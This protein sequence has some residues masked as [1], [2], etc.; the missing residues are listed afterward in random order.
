MDQIV[1]NTAGSW[2]H[3]AALEHLKAL[4]DVSVEYLDGFVLPWN[5]NQDQILAQEGMGTFPIFLRI[6]GLTLNVQIYLDSRI[7]TSEDDGGIIEHFMVQLSTEYFRKCAV[8]DTRSAY[9]I[10]EDKDR[11][12]SF[13]F[14]V[15]GHSD[16]ELVFL[17]LYHPENSLWFERIDSWHVNKS[18]VETDLKSKI[19]VPESLRG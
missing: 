15:M 1:F 6:C 17:L 2:Q 7:S 4:I 13:T 11:A 9:N 8:H 19:I 12:L 14:L 18:A 3:I 10:K 5:G 16:Y